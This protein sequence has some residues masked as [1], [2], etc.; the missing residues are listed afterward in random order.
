VEGVNVLAAAQDTMAMARTGS[1]GSFRIAD[2]NPGQMML[3]INKPEAFISEIRPVAAPTRNFVMELPSGGRVPGRVV[4]KMTRQPVTSFLAG[5]TAPRGGMPMPPMQKQFT[6]NDGTF[7]L[8]SVRP[9][10][11]QVVINAPGYA[12]ARS[13][14]IEVED[15]KTVPEVEVGLETGAKLT[16]RITSPDGAAVAGVSVRNV[17]R[18]SGAP[19]VNMVDDAATTDASGEY[20]IESLEPGEKTFSF[21]RNGYVAQQKSVTIVSGKDARLDAQLSKGIRATGFVV[22]DGGLPIPDT[23][24]RAVSTDGSRED[25][26]DAGGAFT[27]E[28][29]GTGNY[30]FTATKTGFA[31][32]VV[33]DIDIASSGP[34]RIILT[35]GGVINGHVSGLTL[36][37]L[38]QTTVYAGVAGAGAPMTVPVD[39]AGNFRLE[40][41]PSGTVRIGARTGVPFGGSSRSAATKIVDFDGSTAQI[42]IDFKSG[43]IIHGRIT[44]NGAPMASAQVLFVPRDGK[45]QTSASASANAEGRYEIDGLDDG[46]YLVRIMD[47]ALLGTPFTSQYDVRGSDTFDITIKTVTLRGRVTSASDARPLSEANVELRMPGQPAFGG[48]T[49]Q[50]DTAGSFVLEN[51]AAGTYQITVDKPGF[52][53]EARAITIGDQAPADLQFNLSPEPLP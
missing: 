41:V 51:V 25:R 39:R 13:P 23:T 14:N 27:F 1:D 37:E 30:S 3:M 50:T 9:G 28:G 45:S 22:T 24:V 11:T 44:R 29:L 15:G 36:Q 47:M 31:P 6:T 35:S 42:E 8:E 32:G 38:D 34:V 10:S 4:D 12:M 16:G 53:H 46:T 7:M 33:R 19:L 49:A 2:L 43:T 5:V 26:T 20:A 21:S 17:A 48:R 52:G 40:G 18:T